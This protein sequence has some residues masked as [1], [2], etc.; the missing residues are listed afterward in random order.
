MEERL[1]WAALQAALD[2]SARNLLH[3]Y[4]CFPSGE[5]LLNAG[6]EELKQ[7]P[8]LSRHLVE[9]IIERRR[10]I[11][12]E[13]TAEELLK[14]EIKLILLGDLEYPSYLAEIP[15]PPVVLY[16]QGKLP[17]R[18]LPLLAIVGARRATPYG[19]AVAKKLAQELAEAGWGIVSGMARGID[20]AAHSGALA[21]NGYTLAILGCGVDVC[22][23]RE[24]QKLKEQILATGCILS[25]FPP[26]TAPQPHYFPVRNRLVSGCSLGTL[27]VEA[28]DKS[29]ALITAGFALEQ[30]RD[31]F[32]VPGPVTSTRS[33]GTHSLI[34]QGAKLVETVEDIL[35]EFPYLNFPK[36]Q[37]KEAPRKAAEL[38]P[39]EAGLLKFLSLEPV[40]IDQLARLT[41]L[42]VSV[43][44]G[45]LT[46]L[47]IKGLVKQMPGHFFVSTSFPDD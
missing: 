30:G 28:G 40:H 38:T 44:S 31:V 1:C 17:P 5:A 29:G 11:N 34:K 14:K 32:A 45:L 9:K 12:L 10:H 15:D 41:R 47:E 26:G 21:G 27:V 18:A 43:V 7:V 35:V 39:E 22:Y 24:N 2:L 6:E 4:R 23:P 33:K 16:Y 13:K 46:L 3:L 42:S 8:N 20:A 25:E 37:T 19:L 36:Q